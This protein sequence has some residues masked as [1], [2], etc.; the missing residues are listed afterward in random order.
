MFTNVRIRL[1]FRFGRDVKNMLELLDLSHNFI[2]H[3]DGINLS[4]LVS[5]C[6]LN[7]RNNNLTSLGISAIPS[8]ISL[9]LISLDNNNWI[10]DE[11]GRIFQLEMGGSLVY[12]EYGG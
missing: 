4:S 1:F 7:L 6:F 11:K 3:L 9:E 2:S 12:P 10:C 5:L 8:P